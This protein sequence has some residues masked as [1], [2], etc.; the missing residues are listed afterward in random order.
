MLIIKK[1]YAPNIRNK[2][3]NLILLLP[4]RTLT[5]ISSSSSSTITTR[6]LAIITKAKSPHVPKKSSSAVRT[7]LEDSVSHWL[8]LEGSCSH[9]YMY[10]Y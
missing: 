10:L 6:L 8:N 4:S 1:Y 7:I 9:D 2:F 5:T 3:V